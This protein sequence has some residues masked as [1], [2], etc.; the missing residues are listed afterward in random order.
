MKSGHHKRKKEEGEEGEEEEKFNL[1]LPQRT[2][3]NYT[4]PP[5]SHSLHLRSHG[6]G[7][8]P[9]EEDSH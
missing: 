5:I 3:Q 1:Q 6:R 8:A 7:D 4:A 9:P 2:N